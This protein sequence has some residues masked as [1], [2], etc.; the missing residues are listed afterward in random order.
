VRGQRRT[1]AY[2]QRKAKAAAGIVTGAGLVAASVGLG[3]WTAAVNAPCMKPYAECIGTGHAGRAFS[4]M[5]L[6]IITGAVGLIGLAIAGFSLVAL[7]SKSKT[8]QERRADFQRRVAATE[9]RDA[10]KKAAE[11]RQYQAKILSAAN[12]LKNSI[13][14][15]KLPGLGL[16]INDGIIYAS[17]GRGEVRSVGPLIGSRATFTKLKD[18][19]PERHGLV[20]EVAIGISNAPTPRGAVT[21]T[22]GNKTHHRQVEGAS[23]IRAICAEA[24][25]LNAFAQAAALGLRSGEG[26]TPK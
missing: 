22:T 20:Y 1:L 10:A 5:L 18:K 14:P 9:A 8:P 25:R 11:Q 24:D 2:K 17:G 19:P 12:E 16:T 13:A 15:L 23:A 26:Q 7:F 4:G 6:I 21:V 3:I